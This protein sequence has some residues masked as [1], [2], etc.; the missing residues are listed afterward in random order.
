[1]FVKRWLRI[2]SNKDAFEPDLAKDQLVSIDLGSNVDQ[3]LLDRCLKDAPRDDDGDLDVLGWV[4]PGDAANAAD[5]M[6]GKI[7]LATVEV[8]AKT[9]AFLT[10]LWESDTV[11]HGSVEISP[12]TRTAELSYWAQ[13]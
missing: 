9:S 5:V 8:S 11:T 6:I 10:E 3:A 4:R 13:G 2:P 1:M 7:K 12:A